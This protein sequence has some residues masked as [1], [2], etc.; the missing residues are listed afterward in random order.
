MINEFSK[1]YGG[2]VSWLDCCGFVSLLNVRIQEKYLLP[3]FSFPQ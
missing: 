3:L 2:M 1:A